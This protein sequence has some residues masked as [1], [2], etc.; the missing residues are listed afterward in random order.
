MVRIVN[1]VPDERLDTGQVLPSPHDIVEHPEDP[2]SLV[3]SDGIV[4]VARAVNPNQ[5]ALRVD[6]PAI[7]VALLEPLAE[8][9]ALFRS[10]HLIE[11]QDGREVRRSFG[12]D[13]PVGAVSRCQQSTP[14][15]V[16]SLVSGHHKRS[17]DSRIGFG[18]KPHTF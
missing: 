10:P 5:F 11:E 2:A 15:L 7:V 9:D 8:L 16:G 3:V 14:P 13:V 4:S 12:E 6:D 18:Q 1:K 17:V